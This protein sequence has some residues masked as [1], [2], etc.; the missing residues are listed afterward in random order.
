MD[1]LGHTCLHSL[2]ECKRLD[3]HTGQHR[4]LPA[5]QHWQILEAL[6][7]GPVLGL[8]RLLLRLL[9]QRQLQLVVALKVDMLQQQGS[10][11]EFDRFGV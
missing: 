6:V 4:L 1:P 7:L 9:Q 11:V 5:L 2:A 8:V 3:Q 10:R